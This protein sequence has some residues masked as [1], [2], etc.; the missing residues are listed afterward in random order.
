MPTHLTLRNF[1]NPDGCTFRGS[2]HRKMW[3]VFGRNQMQFE[4]EVRVLSCAYNDDIFEFFL[5]HSEL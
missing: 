2:Q 5:Q 1:S 3:N 4:D